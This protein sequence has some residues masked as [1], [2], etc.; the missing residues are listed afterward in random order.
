[1]RSPGKGPRAPVPPGRPPS[2]RSPGPSSPPWPRARL[3]SARP[4]N[5]RGKPVAAPARAD[6][7]A[8]RYR[9]VPLPAEWGQPPSAARI[10][11]RPNGAW[12]PP[13][14]VFPKPGGPMP[15]AAS[16]ADGASSQATGDIMV[17]AEC[18]RW[19]LYSSI[20]ACELPADR[21]GPLTAAWDGGLTVTAWPTDHLAGRGGFE[22]VDAHESARLLRR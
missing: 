14:A 22:D 10:S 4:W 1:M 13:S 20:Q 8:A 16:G 12:F 17:Q 6:H 5:T 2:R 18:R 19:V 9:S 15:H 3:A 21:I 11:G 7:A